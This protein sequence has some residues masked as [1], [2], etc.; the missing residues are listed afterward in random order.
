MAVGLIYISMSK[1]YRCSC[2]HFT[3]RVLLT[4]QD[5]LTDHEGGS[6]I[7][8][9]YITERRPYMSTHPFFAGHTGHE[10]A[11]MCPLTRDFSI[12]R[13]VPEIR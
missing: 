7:H 8:V 5:L 9:L 3:R 2:R 12:A 4:R 10:F 6:Y 13:R 1:R 11:E